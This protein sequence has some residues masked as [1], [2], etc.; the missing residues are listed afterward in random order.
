MPKIR[1]LSTADS[2]HRRTVETDIQSIARFLQE[3]LGQTLVAYMAGVSDPKAVGLWAK[4]KRSPR[5][6]AEERLR[7]IYQVFHL[8][9][10]DSPHTVR[11][12]FVG[13]NP[14]LQDE[15]PASAISE[16]RLKEVFVAAKSYAAGG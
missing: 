11:A 7:T 2:A 15:S 6:N 9:V 8:L 13:L 4:G 1:D 10:G 5:R 14:Q 12:W 16:G 3:N